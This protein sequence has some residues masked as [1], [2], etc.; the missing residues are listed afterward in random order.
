MDVRVIDVNQQC[1]TTLP[2][3][4]EFVALSYVW[5]INQVNQFQLSTKNLIEME[6]TGSLAQHN[7]APTIE[8]S[9]EV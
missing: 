8:D 5:G 1:V 4:A 3:H 2:D 6:K 9:M 7:L